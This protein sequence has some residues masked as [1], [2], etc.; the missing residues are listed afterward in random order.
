MRALVLIVGGEDCTLGQSNG[1]PA[2][3]SCVKV[4]DVD[5]SNMDYEIVVLREPTKSDLKIAEDLTARTEQVFTVG[6]RVNR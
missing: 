3:G 5:D 6:R 4:V 1:I 2:V